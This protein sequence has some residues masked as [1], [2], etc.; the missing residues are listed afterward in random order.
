MKKIVLVLVLLMVVTI[1]T[2]ATLADNV[3]RVTV[4]SLELQ[5]GND[6]EATIESG[7]S[8]QAAIKLDISKLKPGETLSLD[9][10]LKNVGKRPGVI[11]YLRVKATQDGGVTNQPE[12]ITDPDN[13]GD[14]G[15]LLICTLSYDGQ[16]HIL[17][18]DEVLSPEGMSYNPG[19]ILAPEES[20]AF[21]LSVYW[22]NH[23]DDNLGQ[24]DILE[25][26][27]DM[28]LTQL[29]EATD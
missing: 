5:L 11:D 14:L 21:K 26:G 23:I 16:D 9:W 19:I 29:E 20:S 25:T 7:E 1:G 17:P 18:M 22:P 2:T 28:R 15:S 3:R 10:T 13:S 6:N 8:N 24:G 12:S 27:I 4:G